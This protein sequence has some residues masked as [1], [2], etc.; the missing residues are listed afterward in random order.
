MLV[1]IHR[2]GWLFIVVFLAATVILSLLWVPLGWVGLMA[3]AWCVYF[4]RD[5]PRMTPVREGLILAPADGRVQWV[6]PAKPP[7]EMGLGD[8]PLMR[9]SIFLNVF[10]VHINR[11][12]IGGT[13]SRTEYHPGK[14]L[15]AALDKASE[16]NE[17]QAAVIDVADGRKLGVVQIA[18][19][20]ARRIIC[21]LD[22]GQEVRAGD[23]FGLI[24]FGSRTDLYLPDGVAPLVAVGQR[25]VGGETVM[26][27]LESK[28]PQRQA[29]ER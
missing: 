22:A 10:D 8:A 12:P 19:L 9:I 20:V 29:E 18:G 24:R 26:A 3:T 28:E 17:R 2:A 16:D 6:G 25:A 4:F 15:N 13:I 27:D 1:P 11:I 14:F 23:R 5:P 7:E 21:D